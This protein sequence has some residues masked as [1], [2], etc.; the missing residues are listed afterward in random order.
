MKVLQIWSKRWNPSSSRKD[1]EE[2]FSTEKWKGLSIDKQKQHTLRTCKACQKYHLNLQL[3]FPQGP[4][5][6]RVCLVAINQEALGNASKRDATRQALSELNTSFSE[7]FS[8]S[9]TDSLVNDSKAG[10]QKKQSRAE[11]KKVA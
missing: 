8:A 10:V 5:F 11:K 7:V 1:Y 9:F 4:F 2:T 6:I 3:A